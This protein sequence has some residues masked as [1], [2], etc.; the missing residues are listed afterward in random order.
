MIGVSHNTQIHNIVLETVIIMICVS[1]EIRIHI[2]LESNYYDL[3]SVKREAQRKSC[4]LPLDFYDMYD[5]RKFCDQIV[6]L[7]Y[8]FQF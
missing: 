8:N 1:H 7:D 5:P 4:A 3:R 6:H 2:T